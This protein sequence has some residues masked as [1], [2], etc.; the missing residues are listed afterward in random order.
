M[1]KDF[2]LPYTGLKALAAEYPNNALLAGRGPPGTHDIPLL[3]STLSAVRENT[4]VELPIF[5]KSLND[6][7]G[8]RSTATITAQ[9]PVDV[10]LLEGWSLRFEPC[11]QTDLESNWRKGRVAQSHPFKSM[12]QINDNLSAFSHA[13]HHHFDIHIAIRP[14]KY[15]YV[16]QWRLEQEHH[17]MRE[18]GGKGMS[19]EAVR[20]FVDRYMPCYELYG[21]QAI[22]RGMVLE[23]GERR[24]V[25]NVRET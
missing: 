25:V 22:D 20:A 21:A 12:L 2:Y 9:E 10:F 7:Y 16:Y 3:R 19:D 4:S 1:L 14:Q 18:N 23:Y 17:M 15:D 24:E 5:D 13:I 11:S 6:G 8:D